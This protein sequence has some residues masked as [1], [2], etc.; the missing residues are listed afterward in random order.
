[1]FFILGD[2][3]ELKIIWSNVYAR[4]DHFILVDPSAT[5]WVVK[6]DLKTKN[7]LT[8]IFAEN[9]NDPAKIDF[10]IKTTVGA[11][12]INRGEIRFFR[13]GESTPS[14]PAI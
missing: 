8:A 2:G 3:R 10:Y 13:F 6:P 14:T 9:E 12:L 1:M 5:R 11:K 4:L 7:R